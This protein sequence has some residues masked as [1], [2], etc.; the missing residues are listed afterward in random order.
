MN[1]NTHFFNVNF[2][3]LPKKKAINRKPNMIHGV[4]YS[5]IELTSSNFRT[6][7]ISEKCHINYCLG[8]NL[9]QLMMNSIYAHSGFIFKLLFI[10]KA[11]PLQKWCFGYQ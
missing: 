4:K 5:M 8:N 3:A 1:N 10:P 11:I 6:P 9:K 2:L 7:N